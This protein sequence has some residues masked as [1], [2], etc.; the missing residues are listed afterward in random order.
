MDDE[1][2][3][4]ELAIVCGNGDIETVKSMI[5]KGASNWD[6]GLSRACRGGHIEIVKLMIEKGAT[7]WDCGLANACK[8]GN[9]EIV[10]LMI[11]NGANDWNRGMRSVCYRE[12]IEIVELMIEKGASPE[13]VVRQYPVCHQRLQ[14]RTNARE[15][16]PECPLFPIDVLPTVL[17]FL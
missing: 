17:K 6:F 13:Y 3:H 7:Y 2:D 10:Q 4:D 14:D 9:I 8:G 1:D 15:L 16:L 5:G 12:H 11:E